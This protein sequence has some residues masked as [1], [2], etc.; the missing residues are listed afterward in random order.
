MYLIFYFIKQV[1]RLE[2]VRDQERESP[3][4]TELPA[5]HIFEVANL[6]L[7]NATQ[8][9]L[10]VVAIMLVFIS[11][12]IEKADEVRTVLKDLWDLRQAKLRLDCWIVAKF[13]VKLS[14]ESCPLFNY[15]LRKSVMGFI[16]SGLLQAKLNNLQ[17]TL[18]SFS[19]ILL[20]KPT[21]NKY[22]S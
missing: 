2:E 8:V 13:Q 4:F 20:P 5:N 14:W 11:Q 16:E 19:A 12:D 18:L 22:C 10:V 15:S 1:E 17:V 3:I 9:G 6:V 21:L 7:D